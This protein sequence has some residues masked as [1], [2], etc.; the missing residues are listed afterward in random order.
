V[1]D[2]GRVMSYGAMGGDGQPQFQAQVFARINA[3]QKLADAVAAH[4]ERF[5]G[6]FSVDVLAPGTSGP[7]LGYVEFAGFTPGATLATSP[8][9]TGIPA[10]VFLMTAFAI[11]SG[12]LIWP[13]T[14]PR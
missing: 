7:D 14:R 5:T 4:P 11:S 1:F 10:G 2:D 8:I 13:L 12:V 3:G 9:L 6:V